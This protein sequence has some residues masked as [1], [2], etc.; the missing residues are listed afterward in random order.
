MTK[1]IITLDKKQKAEIPSNLNSDRI[2]DIL[3][4]YMFN[5]QY[6]WKEITI[7]EVEEK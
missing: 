1:L 2:I 4:I 6:Q 3:K 5:N 7:K